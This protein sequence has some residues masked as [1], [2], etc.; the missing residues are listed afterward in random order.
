MGRTMT[1]APDL[2]AEAADDPVVVRGLRVV[3]PSRRRGRSPG[4]APVAAV[5]GLD[6]TARRGE[7]T[8]VLGP[9]GAGKSTT[10]ACATG[11]LRPTAGEV[12]VLG[13]DPH[14]A[15]PDQRA[16][17]GVMLQDGGLTTGA[18][19]LSLLRHTAQ[20]YA[21]PVAV[22]DL[23]ERLGI[24]GADGFARTVVRHLS[25]GQRQRLALACALVGRPELVFLDEPTAGMDPQARRT[26]WT[27]LR[28]LV[29]GGLTIVLTT[30]LMDEA[31][32]L[33]DRVVLVDRGRAVADDA[34]DALVAA[35]APRLSPAPHGLVLVAQEA[36]GDDRVRAL[37]GH[38][39]GAEVSRRDARSLLIAP[40]PGPAPGA[41]RRRQVLAQAAA[42]AAAEGI[43]IAELS[44]GA[45]GAVT[46]EDVVL[47]LTGRDEL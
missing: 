31:E 24:T 13:Q 23:A 37:A 46:L 18:P 32:R 6:L 12:R 11:L 38:L 2:P 28:D 39:P 40:G 30:H 17:V 29:A 25:G 20:M 26:T 7:I 16:R 43:D 34:P 3:Y 33:A 10:V 22:D 44:A 9:N 21:R 36:L 15:G 5:D 27:M 19:A 41:A 45:S 47:D 1:S 42:G 14:R 8:A 4:A 35:H